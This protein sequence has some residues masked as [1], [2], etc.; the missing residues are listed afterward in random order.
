[1]SAHGYVLDYD[2]KL[3]Q[4]LKELRKQQADE[5]NIPAYIVLSDAT[6]I[7]LA[8]YFPQTKEELRQ[9]SGFGEMKL[10]K[11]GKK[12]C[13]LIFT[14]CQKNNIQ[15][16]LHLKRPKRLRLEKPER[17]N[18]TKL[19]TFYLFRKGNSIVEIAK[20]RELSITT[21]EGHLVFYVGQGKLSIDEVMDVSKISAIQQALEKWDGIALAPIKEQLGPAYSYGEIRMVMAHL[22]IYRKNNPGSSW[23]SEPEEEYA[24]LEDITT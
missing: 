1:M 3:F 4:D 15:S 12:F 2:A 20:L 9:I 17:E 19:E 22:K 5:E 18:D 13:D 21:I 16:R 11:Y 10:E 7:E 6:L 23:V 14:Y 8:T 24:I